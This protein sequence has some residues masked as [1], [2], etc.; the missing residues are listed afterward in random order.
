MTTS[1]NLHSA[2]SPAHTLPHCKACLRPNECHAGPERGSS[3][4]RQLHSGPEALQR[5]PE[6]GAD[7]QATCRPVRST[8]RPQ[9]GGPAPYQ[10]WPCPEL[11][12]ARRACDCAVPERLCAQ[13]SRQ[14]PGQFHPAGTLPGQPFASDTTWARASGA[15]RVQWEAGRGCAGAWLETIAAGALES[16]ALVWTGARRLC[17]AVHP[18]CAGHAEDCCS[19]QHHQRPHWAVLLHSRNS[20][21]GDRLW[22]GPGC[23]ASHHACAGDRA[24]LS[25]AKPEYVD[26]AALP[27]CA[28]QRWH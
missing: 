25:H 17:W 9:R 26:L 8:G 18:A 27:Y 1:A 28:L 2:G 13:S 5:L 20:A 16:L 14:Q 12:A 19:Q 21:A 7:T 4:P 24:I 3:S 10:A 22:S 11:P 6:S 23:A 15:Q